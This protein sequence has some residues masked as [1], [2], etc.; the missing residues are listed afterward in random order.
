MIGKLL[1]TNR[2]I[3]SRTLQCQNF[4]AHTP[5]THNFEGYGV[6]ASIK[7]ET[8]DV[9]DIRLPQMQVGPNVVKRKSGRDA[10]EDALKSLISEDKRIEAQEQLTQEVFAYVKSVD[11]VMNRIVSLSTHFSD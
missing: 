1:L 7:V 8:S 2:L 9:L 4:C 6:V 11:V 10:A 3:Y 5:D